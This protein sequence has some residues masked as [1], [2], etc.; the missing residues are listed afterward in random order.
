[1]VVDVTP[2][3]FEQEVVRRSAE[4]PVVVDFW[5][6]WCGPC[7][8]LGPVLERFAAEDE[9]KWVLAKVDTEAAPELAEFF[10]IQ[11]IPAV[12]AFRNGEVVAEFVGA[13]PPPAVREWLDGLLPSAAD[14]AAKEGQEAL[15][16]GDRGTAVAAFERAIA[17]QGDH[18]EALLSLAEI[19]DDAD[20]ARELVRRL[21]PRLTPEH[22]A[23]RSRLLLT[24][25]AGGVD[26][27]QLAATLAERPDDLDAR[28]E[29]AHALATHERH[30]EALGHLLEIVRRDRKYRDDGARKAMLGIF[31]VIGARSELAD[32]W[33]SR[34]AEE[35]YK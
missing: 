18:A 32:T 1:M 33:R 16:A 12:K 23:R 13:Q 8:M 29:L 24:L 4:V 14:L 15:A 35:L 3:N 34:L 27:A 17:L 5:A 9:G 22:A 21:H 30:D 6:E 7:R 2:D 28:W 26:E 31:D 11:G 10:Q 19:T 25:D 20:R